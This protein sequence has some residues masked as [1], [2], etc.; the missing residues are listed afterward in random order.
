MDTYDTLHSGVPNAIRAFDE[1]SS[2]WASPKCGI[3][4]DSGDMAYLSR[5]A[6]KMLDDAGWTDCKISVSN[7]LDEYLIQDLLL[8]GRRSICSVWASG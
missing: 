6:R 3:R 8:Q 1:V 5:R 7:S 2:L 4:L